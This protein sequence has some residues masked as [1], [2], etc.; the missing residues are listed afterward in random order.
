MFYRFVLITLVLVTVLPISA[1]GQD[2][3]VL[4]LAPEKNLDPMILDFMLMKEVDVMISVLE[5]SGF[6]V[7]V[8]TASGEP[9]ITAM[10][11]FMPDYKFAE[12]NVDNYAGI[13]LPCLKA[14]RKK[15]IPPEAAALIRKAAEQGK[16]IAAQVLGI[17]WLGEAG[18]LAGKKF[19]FID[20]YVNNS[21][22]KHQLESGIY[23]GKSYVVKDENIITS[24]VCPD[25]AVRYNLPDGTARLTKVLIEE[26]EAKQ[27]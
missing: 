16:P 18:V 12:V 1:T 17:A 13:I 22:L 20:A 25:A 21:R 4:L 7:D 2:L 10:T 8:A 15:P 9:I 26:I 27:K 11:T 24:G 14:P 5:E 6:Q 3:K 19:S 23:R